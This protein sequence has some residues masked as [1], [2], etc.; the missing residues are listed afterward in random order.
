MNFGRS[1]PSDEVRP[2]ARF[3][4]T[5][6]QFAQGGTPGLPSV[7]SVTDS[8]VDFNSGIGDDFNY[9]NGDA[10]S[11][12]SQQRGVDAL[13]GAFTGAKLCTARRFIW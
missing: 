5:A 3:S 1:F 11:P 2:E 13:S 6:R 10:S 12:I 9:G 8:N 4:V 7:L